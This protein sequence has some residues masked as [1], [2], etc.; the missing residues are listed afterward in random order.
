LQP[1]YKES[2]KSN[3]DVICSGEAIGLL[4][5]KISSFSGN[6]LESDI[7]NQSIS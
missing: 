5:N 6:D 4:D 7:E 3:H 2:S 1:N